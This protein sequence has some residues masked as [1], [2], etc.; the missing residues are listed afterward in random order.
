MTHLAQRLDPDEADSLMDVLLS[1]LTAGVGVFDAG[2]ALRM[3]NA[4]LTSMLGL[5]ADATRPG[6]DLRGFLDA[7]RQG[8][9]L[10]DIAPTL[11]LFAALGGG[12]VT[13]IGASGRHLELTVRGLAR[14]GRLAL[15]RDVTERDRDRDTLRE[16]RSRMLHMLEHVT[17]SIVIMDPEG[18]ILQNSDRSGRLL[19]VPP[20]LVVPGRS[21]QDVLRHMYRRGDY[22]FE[23]TEEEFVAQ[24][25]GAILAAGNL[26]F[27][28]PMPNGIWAEYNFRPMTDGH[29]LVIIRDVTAFK[30]QELALRDTLEKQAALAAENARLREEQE[31]SYQALARERAYL[32]AIVDNIDVGI[33]VC[34]SNLNILLINANNPGVTG[35]PREVSAGF[36]DLRDAMRWLLENGQMP[37]EHATIEEDIEARARLLMNGEMTSQVA[38]RNDGRWLRAD[39]KALPDGKW[40]LAHTDVTEA[41]RREMALKDAHAALQLEGERLNTI[42]DNLPDGVAL[43]GADGELVHMNAASRALNFPPETDFRE[44]LTMRDAMRWQLVNAENAMPPAEI[45]ADL[46]R[47]MDIFHASGATEREI[48]RYGRNLAVRWI[49]LP[50]GRRLVVHRDITE[51]RQQE[52]ALRDAHAA[53]EH[54]Y[55]LMRDVLDGML[56]GVSLY[57][58]DG[59][60]LFANRP[61]QLLN[62][63]PD[64]V[65]ATHKT[66]EDRIRWQLATGEVTGM[67]P[68]PEDSVRASL[69]AFRARQRRQLVRQASDGTWIDV[70]WL[71]L[72]G[73]RMLTIHRDITALKTQEQE[74]LEARRLMGMV[75]DN[76]TDGVTLYSRDGTLAY[77]NQ[78]F[79]RVQDW[80]PERFAALK[81]FRAMADGLLERG[82]IDEEFH[83]AALQR[84][85]DADGSPKLLRTISGRWS[86]G[87]FH[88][89]ADGGTLGIFRDVTELRERELELR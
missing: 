2:G 22:G 48:S 65:F 66:L 54:A 49:P 73:G 61:F 68:D 33:A 47:R 57:G 87:S 29:M 3:A 67:L 64:D 26:T 85:A 80:T 69:A 37:R 60:V 88:R 77:T 62:R 32:Q 25:R 21:H 17:D 28:A 84:F 63:M 4:P 10:N 40:L 78:S 24:R 52:A 83:A 50:G 6:T 20:E 13:W 30:E 76:M 70:H 39:W 46:D 41:M 72:P 35:V 43:A 55:G 19:A 38:Q 16:E 71:P 8:G 59:E 7:A 75:L 23:Q 82:S 11:A 86:E 15:W 9:L 53:T 27:T 31:A 18:T 79:Y 51:L 44:I 42:L 45:E 34:D 36:R 58:P 12:V 89:L 81:T 74:V 56:D 5:P 14:D 1:E